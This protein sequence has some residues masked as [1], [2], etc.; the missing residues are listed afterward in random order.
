[1]QNGLCNEKTRVDVLGV[2]FDDISIEQA[3]ARAFDIIS[4]RE[5]TYVVT[6]NPEI[7]WLCRRNVGLGAALSGAGLVLPDGIGIILGARILGTPLR[8]GRVPG[9][10]FAEALFGRMAGSGG[11]VFLFGA[12]PGVA[13]EA[14]RKLAEKHPGLVICGTADGYFSDDGPIVEQINAA[15]PDLLL[16]CLGAPKQ[17]LWIAENIG[18]LRVPLCAGL[19]GSLD[20]FAGNV[21]RAPVF[22]QRLGLEWFYRLLREPRRIMRSLV[23]PLFV[24]A[25][26]LQRLRR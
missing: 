12:K 16:V 17:E 1:M 2:G 7:V 3:A 25:V 22:F 13:E 21:K 20:V 8:G 14:G 9:I 26:V 23:L 19:G 5:G 4:G 6:P 24:L 11:S 18:R 10:D 15:D